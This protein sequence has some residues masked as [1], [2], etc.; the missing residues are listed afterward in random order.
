MQIEFVEGTG[1]FLL[2]DKSQI[3]RRVN[4]LDTTFSRPFSRCHVP[5]SS[6]SV[7]G[8]SE[9]AIARQVVQNKV[10][11]ASVKESSRGV[12]LLTTERSI[13]DIINLEGKKIRGG[14]VSI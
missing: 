7:A 11:N 6:T 4:N 2:T 5:Y 12:N 10:Q 1:A 13:S 3:Y 8:R 9:F 14:Q